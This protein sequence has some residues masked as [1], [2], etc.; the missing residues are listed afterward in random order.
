MVGLFTRVGR[1]VVVVGLCTA[2]VAPAAVANTTA[3]ASAPGEIVVVTINAYQRTMDEARLDALANGLMTRVGGTAPDIILIQEIV[4]EPL[5]Y[6]RDALNERSGTNA[7]YEVVGRVYSESFN[8]K[9]KALLN[10]KTMKF[11]GYKL[12]GDACE[13]KRRYQIIQATEIATGKPVA[14]AGVHIAPFSNPAG[15]EQCKID[16]ANKTREMMAPYD[17]T[18]SIVGDFNRRAMDWEYEC[19]ANEDRSTPLQ[20]YVDITMEKNGYSYQDTVRKHHWGLGLD[21]LKDQWTFEFPTAETLCNDTV[22]HRRMRMDYVFTS[23]S[24]TVLEA[25][26]DK[27]W[28]HLTDT[29]NS[30]CSEAG[31]KYSDHRF[32]WA[33][34]TLPGTPPPEPEPEPNATPTASFTANCTDLECAFADASTDSDGTIASRS[35]SFGEGSATS[36][37][38]APSHTYA[39]GGTYT[40]SLT[41]TDSAGATDTASKPVTVTAPASGGIT[42]SARGYKVKGTKNVDL[43]WADAGSSSVDVYRN[44]AKVATTANDG[45]YTDTIGGKSGG[46][47]RYEVCEAGTSTCSNEASV[48]F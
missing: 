33:R 45:A 16:N 10:T 19:D 3:S 15:T 30:N 6:L 35:W 47:Y 36:T 34:L 39:A 1:I 21:T 43:T 8:V 20:W 18:G 11:N 31:C 4:S 5:A 38:Q 13:D 32:V 40:V 12:W 7:R 17:E 46:T 44:N 26:A 25:H 37:E 28:G 23:S 9:V 14:A 41:V 29:G 24:M 27:G 42:L 22:G 2:L 48:T